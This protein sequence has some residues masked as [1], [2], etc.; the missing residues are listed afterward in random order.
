MS[1]HED[2]ETLEEYRYESNQLNQSSRVCPPTSEDLSLIERLQ[3][4][5]TNSKEKIS[6]AS[7]VYFVHCQVSL[8]QSMNDYFSSNT[9]ILSD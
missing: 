4:M 5:T 8:N 7:L 1:F 6:V 3:A 2:Q 9:V